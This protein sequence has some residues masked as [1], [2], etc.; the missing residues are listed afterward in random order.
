VIETRKASIP[1]AYNTNMTQNKENT[2]LTLPS[3]TELYRQATDVASLCKEIV[4]RT[5]CEIQQ[6]KYV[7]VEGWQS[8]ATAHGCLP[9]IK[10]VTQTE[11]GV[12]AIAE[13]IQMSTGKSLATAEGYVGSDEPTW[14]GGM[15]E[16][17]NKV[18]KCYEMKEQPKRADYAIR[19]MAQ[20]RAISRVCRSA[21]AHVVVM[22]DAGLS[23]TP[24]EE[25]P[26]GGF[27]DAE[28]T[29]EH[30]PK[31]DAEFAKTQA[32][33]T[34]VEHK[35]TGK[36]E[37]KNVT[38]VEVPREE[39]PKPTNDVSRWEDTVI[40]FGKNKGVKI[41]ELDNRSLSW[42]IAEWKPKPYN[43]KIS[44]EDTNLRAALDEAGIFL[45]K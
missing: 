28:T 17:W 2:V 37:P 18:K 4:L 32:K 7:K 31:A 9:S 11:Q 5:A 27:N 6:R 16:K 21:F 39:A 15:V 14:Y 34:P 29:V 23:T 26:Y 30:D 36:A 13:L 41:G 8:I 12:S 42:Y 19:A 24:A 3:N 1:Q 25:V 10:S 44:Q 35:P 33:V 40:H 22:M 43:G 38:P 45:D 20:T